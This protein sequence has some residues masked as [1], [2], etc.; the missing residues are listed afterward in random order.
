MRKKLISLLLCMVLVLSVLP[1][2]AAAEQNSDIV[3]L[4][5]NDV[6]CAVEGYSKLSALK[7]Q[8]QETYDHVGTVSAGDYLQGGSL[9]AISQGYYI[10]EL[11]NAVG[12]DVVTLG[13]HEFDY[14]MPRLLELE[15]LLE[16][17]ITSCNFRKVGQEESVFAPY[18]MVSYGDV[19][20]AY[21]GITTPETLTSSFPK[22]FLDAQGNYAY[23]FGA[24]SLPAIVQNTV[25]RAR[26]AGADYVLA[27][28]HI[29]YGEE[30]YG[31]DVTW[32]IR[33]TSGIDAVLDGHS[34]SVIEAMEVP[35][36]DGQPVLLTSTGTQFQYIGKL[37]LSD[38]SFRSEL[39]STETLEAT[40][41][42]IDALI[43]RINEEFNE[44]GR[45]KIAC[46][47]VD[48]ATHDEAGNRL[49]RNGETNLGDLCADAFRMCTG[50]DIAYVN[51]GG[52][53][54]P[55]ARGD[56]T[57]ND[58]LNV[59]PFNNQICVAQVSGQV[60]KDMLEN[61]MALW[62]EENGTF[63]HVSG[64]T[65]SVNKAIASSVTLD[66]NEMFTG[67]AG[68]YRIYH[69]QV[70]NRETGLY[71]PLELDKTYT[72]AAV[73]YYLN[74]Y[75]G[76]MKMLEKASD[77]QTYGYSDVDILERYLT[78][79]LE[80]VVGAQYA[81]MQANITFTDGEILPPQPTQPPAA[82]PEEVPQTQPPAVQA[83]DDT[84]NQNAAMILTVVVFGLC[85]LVIVLFRK[86]STRTG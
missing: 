8:L 78:E 69:I 36:K 22:Q 49:V 5:E 46:T 50:A 38:G 80:G 11:M 3:I 86:R 9:G 41:P 84:G 7:L 26:E 52:I 31:G 15:A 45:R 37:T 59:F 40:D 19:D 65:F 32:L 68:P 24:E 53:R 66:E 74:E 64:I 82:E 83:P 77:L 79:H 21:V 34:H 61:A 29:G 55:I 57:Y 25:D 2:A 44:L 35:N 33:E 42:E 54:M 67:V 39:I 14:R 17:E 47:E 76:G 81:N 6:H 70:C 60:I 18:T 56:I 1:A 27:L 85:A 73:G 30:I 13:N 16:A 23:T 63:P 28:S 75:G 43:G 51:G 72:L 58:L 48:L 71:E 62:P 12:Y 4:Y 20:I 10:V